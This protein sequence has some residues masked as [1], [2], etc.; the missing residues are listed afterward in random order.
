M[1]KEIWKNV[2]GHKGY[3][4]S[5]L[6]N[7]KSI[8]RLVINSKNSL[9]KYKGK[10]L[11]GY[12]QKNGY[13][14]VELNNAYKYSVHRLVALAFIKNKDNKPM[15]NHIDNNCLN[16]E[17]SNLEWCTQSENI[18]HCVRQGRNST[19]RALGEKSG[20]SKLKDNDILDIR[21]LYKKISYRKIGK[22]F[23]VNHSTIKDIMLYRTWTH[24]KSN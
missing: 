1:T 11:K 6:G 7:V 12:I 14:K 8:D 3:K 10:N 17:V 9:C 2:V 24:I 15:V 5:N 23:G 21:K 22:I 13:H 4:V 19:K 18:L 20:S 16:N